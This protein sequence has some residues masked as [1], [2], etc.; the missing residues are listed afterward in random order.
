MGLENLN[1]DELLAK[2]YAKEE[3][4][5]AGIRYK[6]ENDKIFVLTVITTGFN[7]FRQT[8]FPGGKSEP[9]GTPLK[10]GETPLETLENEWREETGRRIKKARYVYHKIRKDEHIQFF[11]LVEEDEEIGS[12]TERDYDT[13]LPQWELGTEALSNLYGQHK[14]AFIKLIEELSIS[15]KRFCEAA[16]RSGLLV[17]LKKIKSDYYKQKSKSNK[18][19][20]EPTKSLF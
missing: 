3:S 10:T 9:G 6:I 5:S 18:Q 2:Q 20:V 7:W 8:K 12:P 4:F 16:Y 14:I 13:T 15:N 17:R 11:F 19:T 1:I